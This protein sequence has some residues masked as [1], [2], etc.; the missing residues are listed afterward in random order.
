MECCPFHLKVK[1]F[2]AAAKSHFT[3]LSGGRA[4]RSLSFPMQTT[5]QHSRLSSNESGSRQSQPQQAASCRKR[6]SC[7]HS[8]HNQR[9]SPLP[10][11]HNS[12]NC[13]H[14]DTI[15]LQPKKSHASDD[16]HSTPTFHI[17]IDDMYDSDNSSIF[18]TIEQHNKC[19]DYKSDT[20]D[21]LHN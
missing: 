10:N 19:T 2:I 12:Q 21:S 7:P 15:E 4:H 6:N 1:E 9:R 13:F 16:E 11:R 3:D 17:F 8:Y 18:D 5:T 14:I 20:P